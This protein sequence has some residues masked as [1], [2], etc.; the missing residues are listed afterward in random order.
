MYLSVYLSIYLYIHT[1]ISLSLYIYIYIDI[2]TY[3]TQGL[4][5]DGG[6]LR[7][8]AGARRADEASRMLN[9]QLR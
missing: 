1:Y 6:G 9:G 4:P 8:G 5:A 7:P 3:M 2:H